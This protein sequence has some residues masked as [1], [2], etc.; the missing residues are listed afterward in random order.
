MRK[1]SSEKKIAEI[2]QGN[3]VFYNTTVPLSAFFQ[4]LS[5]GRSINS[6][7]KNCPAVDKDQVLQLLKKAEA[8]LTEQ[9]KT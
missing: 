4:H 6:F 3:P 5:R 9:F 1:I 7:L 2:F 8:L